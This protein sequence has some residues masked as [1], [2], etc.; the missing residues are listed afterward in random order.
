LVAAMYALMLWLDPQSA[1][2]VTLGGLLGMSAV[3]WSAKPSYIAIQ[4]SEKSVLVS[5][6]ESIHYRYVPSRDH[7]VPPLPRW[8]RWKFNFVKFCA[9]ANW[10]RVVGPAN[11]LRYLAQQLMSNRG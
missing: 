1:V 10:V 5:A 6:L 8:L 11:I 4:E 9:D 7:W 3:N 2:L